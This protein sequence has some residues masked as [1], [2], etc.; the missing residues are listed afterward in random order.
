M[1][2]FP[3][4]LATPPPLRQNPPSPPDCYLACCLL[5]FPHLA[6]RASPACSSHSPSKPAHHPNT[7]FAMGAVS[8]WPSGWEELD[9]ELTEAME[10]WAQVEPSHRYSQANTNNE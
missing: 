7:P 4:S 3:T 2:P 6:Y 9:T 8:Q 1:P 10:L 5:L